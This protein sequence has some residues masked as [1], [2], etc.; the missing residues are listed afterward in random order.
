MRQAGMCRASN[1]RGR[2]SWSSTTRPRHGRSLPRTSRREAGRPFPL[3]SC[4]LKSMRTLAFSDSVRELCASPR[5]GSAVYVGPHRPRHR[6]WSTRAAERIVSAT[7]CDSRSL[8]SSSGGSWPRSA[9]RPPR[10]RRCVGRRPPVARPGW[11]LGRRGSAGAQ[12]FRSAPICPWV[13]ARVSLCYL[14]GARPADGDK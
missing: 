11:R 8:H 10:A 9:P 2:R 3:N 13:S 7:K 14:C 12:I 5:E 6:A 4:R 1:R